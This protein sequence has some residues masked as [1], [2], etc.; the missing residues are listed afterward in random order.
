VYIPKLG[1]GI[2]PHE[3]KLHHEKAAKTVLEEALNKSKLSLDDI[4]IISYSA[5]PGIPPPL[6]FTANFALELSRKYNKPSIPVNHCCTHLEIGKLMTKTKDPIF[7]YLSG[8]NTQII[9]FVERRYR[10][11]GEALDISVGNCIDVVAREMN[12]PMPGGPEIEKI[13]KFGK[14]I[15]LPYVVKGMD[16]SF[17][18]I[19]T[20]AINLLKKGVAK[21][22]VAYSLQEICFSMLVEVTERA[23][24]HTGKEEVLLV[25]GV[26][27]NKRLQEMISIMC[28][29]RG[30]KFYVV[31]PEYSSDNGVMIAWCGLLHYKYGCVPK[32]KDKILP[33]WRIDQVPICWIK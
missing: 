24:A 25:G 10:I 12:L 16:V 14:Y 27:A 13:A 33:K 2:V 28:D 22:D 11:F 5:G 29:E 23:L 17:S 30:A 3:A 21:E 18:G 26:A 20:A 8:G 32:V 9:A 31:P 4:D 1:Q 19:Q 7:V 15:E 6:L